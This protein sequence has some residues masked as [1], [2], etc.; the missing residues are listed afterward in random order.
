MSSVEKPSTKILIT[1]VSGLILAALIYISRHWLPPI[2]TW[3]AHLVATA[4]HWL[5]TPHAVLG[6]V[7]I[8]LLAGTLIVVIAGARRT[9][10]VAEPPKSNWRDFV[11]FEYLGVL[12]RWLYTSHGDIHSLVSFC[13]ISGCDMQTFPRLGQW[14]GG[15][16]E[17]THYPCDR[18]GHTPEIEGS[19]HEIESTVTREI[20]RLLRSD[21]WKEHVQIAKQSTV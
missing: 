19:E 6:W 17:T 13:P 20:Q 16:R 4:W 21:G 9:R 14:Y 10:H 3:L 11:Q 1:V 5:I 2:F 7:L 15:S 18:C 8:I 12:W